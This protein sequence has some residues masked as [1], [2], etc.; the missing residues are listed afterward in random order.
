MVLGLPSSF[1]VWDFY[2]QFLSSSLCPLGKKNGNRAETYKAEKQLGWMPRLVGGE[3]GNAFFLSLILN[4]V[5]IEKL[6][7]KGTLLELS[8]AA[9]L[10]K[11]S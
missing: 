2:P 1:L 3:G 4:L 5:E 7:L 8:P 11:E 9:N 10:Q 6:S